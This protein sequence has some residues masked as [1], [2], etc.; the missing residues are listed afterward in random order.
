MSRSS[1]KDQLS[2]Q[3]KRLYQKIRLISAVLGLAALALVFADTLWVR[4]LGLGGGVL[5]FLVS[6]IFNNARHFGVRVLWKWARH[7]NINGR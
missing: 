4:W 1:F 3:E 6:A 7:F 5:F 2:A